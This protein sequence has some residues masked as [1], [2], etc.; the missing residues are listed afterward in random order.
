[1]FFVVTTGRSGSKSL[2]EILNQHPICACHHEPHKILIKLSAE[3]CHHQIDAH[4]LQ[5]Y[6][7]EPESIFPYRISYKLYGESDHRLSF[8][9]PQLK[10]T[11]TS[12][13][14]LW[15]LRDGRSVIAST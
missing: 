1:M 3:Y 15:L 5:S 7:F 8:F 14:F 6:L 10:E 13:K 4:E 11:G 9:I 12:T 2:S